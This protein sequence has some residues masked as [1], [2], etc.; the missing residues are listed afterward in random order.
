MDPVNLK[1]KRKPRH[2]HASES[3]AEHDFNSSTLIQTIRTGDFTQ[4]SERESWGVA[5][6]ILA[7]APAE[8]KG[9]PPVLI[10][11]L[12]PQGRNSSAP[13]DFVIWMLSHSPA[14]WSAQSEK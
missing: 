14:Q 9:L 11:L 8:A 7:E 6:A 1:N 12:Q 2:G 4:N 3:H 5:E 10:Y 13:P